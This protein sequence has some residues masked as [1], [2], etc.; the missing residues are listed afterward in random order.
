MIKK[1]FLL[2]VVIL[3]L[4]AG[5]IYGYLR[6]TYPQ[7]PLKTT[8]TYYF[9]HLRH[10]HVPFTKQ[11]LGFLP[12]WRVEDIP[13]IR[14]ENI[15][16]L[17]YFGI[18]PD[19]DGTILREPNGQTDPG[20]RE[21]NSEQMKDL[22]TRAHIMGTKV[23]LT[24]VTHDPAIVETF[25]ESKSAQQ[26]LINEL[27]EQVK[28]RD[29]DGINI[30]FEYL[31][32]IEPFYRKQFVIFS[33]R[34]SRALREEAPGTVLSISVMP[35]DA[36]QKENL[37]DVKGLAPF[38]DR[39]IVMSYDYYGQSA[40]ISAPV[41]PMKGFKEE[42]YF[43]DVETT[44]E[45]YLKYIP[46]NKILMGVPYYGWDRAVEHGKTKNSLTFPGDNANNYAASVS[47]SYARNNKDYKN[48][49]CQWDNLAQETWCWYTDKKTGVDHQVWLA[50]NK[51]IEARFNYANKEDF[52]GIAIWVLGYD[53]GYNDLWN[54]IKEKFS[55]Q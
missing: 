39:F 1:A 51:S 42:K 9:D 24:V 37:L 53:K 40:D 8:A 13:N 41:A 18:S 4:A 6:L 26:Q 21:W 54:L 34:L 16:E 36:R 30:D 17:N 12:Y 14:L 3:I 22:V 47:Y 31:G 44:Y 49:P 20:W 25:L 46:K 55:G 2:L 23:S 35:L 43:F 11:V 10:P 7:L 45:D 5:G 29:L 32:E 27:V 48:A 15:S 28:T 19:A 38:Y 33:G 50:D 52:A